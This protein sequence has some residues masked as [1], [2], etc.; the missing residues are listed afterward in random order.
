M[1]NSTVNVFALPALAAAATTI[2]VD[3]R[4]P[5]PNANST[6]TMPPARHSTTSPGP[7]T[8]STVAPGP[9]PCGGAVGAASFASFASFVSVSPAASL[10][11]SA[12]EPT[13][14]ASCHDAIAPPWSQR[15]ERQS[16]SAINARTWDGSCRRTHAAPSPWIA[17]SSPCMAAVK[18]ARS[19]ATTV[20]EQ[21]AGSSAMR[22]R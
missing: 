5:W 13:V 4:Y 22:A 17:A 2:A 10:S 20:F 9:C 7:Y 6:T 19:S 12:R 18:F 14:S 3:E 8:V 11:P 1:L 15:P 21:Y 16:P